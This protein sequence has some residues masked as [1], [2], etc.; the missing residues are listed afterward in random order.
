MLFSIACSLNRSV[1]PESVDGGED[2]S[3]VSCVQVP[4]RATS[5]CTLIKAK[6][7]VDISVEVKTANFSCGSGCSVTVEGSKISL[8]LYQT[9]CS[10]P[11][12]PCLAS[13]SARCIVP[14]LTE[15]TYQLVNAGD[16]ASVAVPFIVAPDGTEIGCGGGGGPRIVGLNNACDTAADCAAVLSDPCERTCK[17]P[18]LAV[19]KNALET[20]ETAVANAA[21]SCDI[22][23]APTPTCASCPARSVACSVE[24]KCV[25]R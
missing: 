20:Y 25:L 6:A 13:Q 9:S 3:T 16:S 24:K 1:V 5:T 8:A 14:P 7:G 4:D 10:G 2:S 21:S 18:D 15:G 11:P 17:C 22:R 19:N 12:T 23:F